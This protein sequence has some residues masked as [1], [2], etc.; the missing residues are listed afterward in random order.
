M[1]K[2]KENEKIKE[3]H[4]G[5]YYY[6]GNFYTKNLVK[7]QKVYNEK[8]I[9]IDNNEYRLW[10]PYRSK[11]AAALKNGLENIPFKIDSKVLYLGASTG[12]TVSHL[13][14]I[15]NEGII[16]AV[17]ISEK[18]MEKLIIVAEKRDNIIPILADARMPEHY[19]DIGKVD[20]IYQDIAQPD[21]ERILTENIRIFKPKYAMLCLKAHS[22]DVTKS[23]KET[24]NKALERLKNF[25]IL[26]VINLEPY[27]K[28][29]YFISI[30]VED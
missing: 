7:G 1:A 24:L 28:E 5:I 12:T 22:I 21:Q 26:Q 3:V 9:N 13:S 23:K 14:D 30:K 17:E 6:K 4:E 25:K 2:N 18:M 27:D 16:Y 8:I 20:I 19:K 11:L 15:C 10:D 29:H